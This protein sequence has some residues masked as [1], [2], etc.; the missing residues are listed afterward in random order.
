M[1]KP[2]PF[3]L[4]ILTAMAI[5]MFPTPS[6]PQDPRKPEAEAKRAETDAGDGV[7]QYCSNIA[8]FAADARIAWQ[9]KRMDDLEAQLKQRIAD[10]EAKETESKEWI[11]K[12]EALMKKAQ[13]GVVAIY[14]K[15]QPEAAAAQMGVMEDDTAA[16]LLSKLN[17]RVSSA[18]LNEMEAGKAAKLTD[19]IS[20]AM[21]DRKKS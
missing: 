4:G 14:A 17:P 19:L 15:M 13:D 21:A 18:I 2:K 20:G 7:Q 16:A 9:M 10:L 11:D 5:A 12:R 3:T 6:L 8:S 1:L